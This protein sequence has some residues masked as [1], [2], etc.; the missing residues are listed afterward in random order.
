MRARKKN[1]FSKKK[2]P[3]TFDFRIAG[4]I[5]GTEKVPAELRA[6]ARMTWR[7]SGKD[8]QDVYL[9]LYELGE[10]PKRTRISK[11][12]RGNVYVTTDPYTGPGN[13]Q[14]HIETGDM[15]VD[16]PVTPY[17]SSRRNA[18]YFTRR[19]QKYSEAYNRARYEEQ[20]RFEKFQADTMAYFASNERYQRYSQQEFRAEA[21]ALRSF[22]IDNFGIWNCDRPFPAAKSNVVAKFTDEQGNPLFI[23]DGYLV[24]K[25]RNSVIPVNDFKKFPL[26]RGTEAIFWAVLPGNKLAIIYPQEF[27][28]HKKEK[29]R[30]RTFEMQINNTALN[31]ASELKSALSFKN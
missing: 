23:T 5:A 17:F 21:A 1:W 10:M 31:D 3:E 14:V 28:K 9:N 6:L 4:T 26:V 19:W 2:L 30:K 22:T 20:M 12:F 18:S 7:Y 25:S 11:N 24:L 8:A 15:T 27:A 13:Y 16:I 29:G